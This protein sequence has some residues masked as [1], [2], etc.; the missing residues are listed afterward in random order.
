VPT[1]KLYPDELAANAAAREAARQ[2]KRAELV[3][4]LIPALTKSR[5]GVVE[6][7]KAAKVSFNEARIAISEDE[8]LHEHLMCV[9]AELADEIRHRVEMA[10]VGERPLPNNEITMTIFGAKTLAGL[11]ERQQVEHSGRVEYGKP[12]ANVGESVPNVV[13]FPVPRTG[14][15]D[16]SGGP[17]EDAPQNEQNGPD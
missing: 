1:A 4:K 6:A 13:Q 3:A 2:A 17:S 16:S 9:R 7:A 12:P 11:Q 5:G 15:D 8:V 14:T 10:A